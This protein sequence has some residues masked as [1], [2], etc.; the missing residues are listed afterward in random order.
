MAPIL[1]SSIVF[2]LACNMKKEASSQP[3]KSDP[4]K[5]VK[6]EEQWRQALTPMQYHVAREKG[7]ERAFSGEYWDNHAAGMY[8]C[9]ACGEPLFNSDD[10]FDS[11]SGWPSFTEPASEQSVAESTDTS[12]GMRRTEVTCSRCGSHLGHLFPDGPEPTGM[13]YCINSAALKFEPR[14]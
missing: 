4:G 13:R 12:H 1:L 14:K 11:G 9:V 2:A 7:T 5:V 10:K 3:S 8:R 6:T